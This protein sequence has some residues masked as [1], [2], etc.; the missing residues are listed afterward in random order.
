MG[1]ACFCGHGYGQGFER[2]STCRSCSAPGFW[3]RRLYPLYLL[4]Y[5]LHC[6]SFFGLTSFILR[7][8]K[9]N[10][11]KELQWR[12]QVSLYLYNANLTII[13]LLGSTLGSMSVCMVWDLVPGNACLH[14]HVCTRRVK[15][16]LKICATR[17]NLQHRI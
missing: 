11:Q 10:P 15:A 6:S 13:R 14:N 3:L 8:L 5:S 2:L 1:C 12:L 4:Y 17:E 9:G 16:E 7:I